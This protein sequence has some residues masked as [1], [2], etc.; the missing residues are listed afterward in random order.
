MP[1]AIA[2][3]PNA[4]VSTEPRLTRMARAF[5]VLFLEVEAGQ[6]SRRQLQRL[7]CPTLFARLDGVWLRPGT[8]PGRVLAVHTAAPAP[9]RCEVVAVV[10]R[11]PRVGALAFTLRRGAHG[12]RVE[13]LCRPEDG[14]LPDPA[15]PVPRDEPDI[16][17]LVV[18]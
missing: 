5:A 10:E 9:G 12:W 1:T 14:P 13:E 17:E 3:H 6:R 8:P 18:V 2:D 16:F 7:M 4:A 11:G 15:Y